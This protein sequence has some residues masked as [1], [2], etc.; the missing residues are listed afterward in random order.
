MPHNI[1]CR[2]LSAVV[3]QLPH[4]PSA[5]AAASDSEFAYTPLH[6]A[7]AL[8]ALGTADIEAARYSRGSAA[9]DWELTVISGRTGSEV[10]RT[11]AKGYHFV[12]VGTVAVGKMGETIALHSFVE[13]CGCCPCL[14][15]VEAKGGGRDLTDELNLGVEVLCNNSSGTK[16]MCGSSY[17]L[18]EL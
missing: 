16:R 12:L 18:E 8:G 10:V 1:H 11:V 7:G 6:S 4:L 17:I 5:V 14:F 3:A 2:H 9:W 13:E 15:Y